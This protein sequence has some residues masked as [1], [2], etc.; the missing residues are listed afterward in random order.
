EVDPK[1]PELIKTVWGGG[2][3]FSAEVRHEH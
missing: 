3:M 2:Y 1:K